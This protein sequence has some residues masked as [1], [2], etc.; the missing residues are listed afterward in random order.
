MTN[1]V[2]AIVVTYHSSHDVLRRLMQ[3]VQPQVAQIV[4]VD[5]SDTDVVRTW[6]SEWAL[7][8]VEYH[9][10]GEN[11]GI[12]AAQNIGLERA[13]ALGA[14]QVLLLDHDSLPEPDM[15]SKLAAAAD[16]LTRSGVKLAAVGPRYR[17]HGTNVSSRFVQLGALKYRKVRCNAARQDEVIPADILIAS[18]CLIPMASLKDIGPMDGSLFIDLVDTEWV[19]RAK[20]KGYR[21][22]GVCA[23]IMNHALGDSVLRVWLGKMRNLPVHSPLRMYYIYRNSVLM[24]RRPYVPARWMINNL[25]M[26][27]VMF[28]I[29]PTRVSPRGKYLL[30]M[31]KGLRDGFL[32]RTGRYQG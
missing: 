3:A 8:G 20:S 30:M 14:S 13:A 25:A 11:I 1:K 31:L 18:G 10:V 28:A 21:S 29:F 17:L 5:N 12:G 23:A 22:F 19:I 16:R 6:L 2:V 9:F 4:I 7:Q 24:A 32:G 27:L 15:V 26:L